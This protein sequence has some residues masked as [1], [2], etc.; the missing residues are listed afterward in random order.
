M[1]TLATGQMR[2]WTSPPPAA[3]P[4]LGGPG[5]WTAD[6]PTPA[7]GQ[8]VVQPGGVIRIVPTQ[9]RLLN[10]AAPGTNLAA[11][12]T[13]VTLHGAGSFPWPFIIPMSPN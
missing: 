2:Q 7:L 6:S 9:I 12:S 13:L 11:V 8:M 5:A 4:T 1:I 3:T 10:T